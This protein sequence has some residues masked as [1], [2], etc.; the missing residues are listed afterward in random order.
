MPDTA[1]VLALRIRYDYSGVCCELHGWLQLLS[2]IIT[3]SA[4]QERSDLG[5]FRGMASMLLWV[6]SI[7]HDSHFPL[8]Q[9]ELMASSLACT[10][11]K[12]TAA[13]ISGQETP[14]TSSQCDG[15][16]IILLHIACFPMCRTEIHSHIHFTNG[17]KILFH[18]Q[19]DGTLGEQG[20][21]RSKFN[22]LEVTVEAAGTPK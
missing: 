16:K 18:P 6:T 19:E 12:I 21:A 9:G 7:E 15:S 10:E 2:H 14:I 22:P 17:C 1:V 13:S 11:G 3:R 4:T 20:K 5:N 8:N